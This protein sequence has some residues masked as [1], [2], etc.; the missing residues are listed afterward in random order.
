MSDMNGSNYQE[1]TSGMMVL[2]R[3]VR[4]LVNQI[5]VMNRLLERLI[6]SMGRRQN[7]ELTGRESNV[8][9]G[10]FTRLL[11]EQMG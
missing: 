9:T 3:K 1:G 6:E 4:A 7:I 10:P 2:I 11:I 5:H 8:W